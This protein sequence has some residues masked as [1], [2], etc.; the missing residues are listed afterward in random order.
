MAN[1]SHKA[2]S[3]AEAVLKVAGT[4]QKKKEK[5]KKKEGGKKKSP[6][7]LSGFK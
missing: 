6:L 3:S 1:T 5:G 2:S 4:K 7:P